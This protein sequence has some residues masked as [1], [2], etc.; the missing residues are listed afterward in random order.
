MPERTEEQSGRTK[1]SKSNAI[2]R[3]KLRDKEIERERA[4]VVDSVKSVVVWNEE[5]RTVE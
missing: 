5:I 1:P 3:V 2:E 4:S